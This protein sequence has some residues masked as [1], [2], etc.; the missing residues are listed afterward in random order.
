M[1]HTHKHNRKPEVFRAKNFSQ[2]KMQK[3]P[4]KRG[5]RGTS[6]RRRTPRTSDVMLANSLRAN[7]MC[8]KR[9]QEISMTIIMIMRV[10]KE[11]VEGEWKVSDENVSEWQWGMHKMNPQQQRSSKVRAASTSAV[12]STANYN[13]IELLC[14]PPFAPYKVPLGWQ[15]HWM[16]LKKFHVSRGV[17]REGGGA[18]IFFFPAYILGLSARFK[19]HVCAFLFS[20]SCGKCSN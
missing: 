9:E 19:W 13:S 3:K 5:K 16:Q 7:R 11:C 1:L 12:S 15:L 18:V 20:L 8:A 14:P 4:S 10:V 2:N 17:Y 6:R